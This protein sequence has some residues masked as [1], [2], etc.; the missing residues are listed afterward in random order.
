MLY[1]QGCKGV[2]HMLAIVMA[3]CPDDAFVTVENEVIFQGERR[4]VVFDI[5]SGSATQFSIE[6]ILYTD[7]KVRNPIIVH[8]EGRKL[9]QSAIS[10]KWDGHLSDALDLTLAN[11][12]ARFTMPVRISCV[13]LISAIICSVSGRDMCRSPYGDPL[14]TDGFRGLLGPDGL[15]RVRE[16]LKRIFLCEPSFMI[17]QSDEAYNNL[18]IALANAVPSNSCQCNRCFKDGRFTNH[19]WG[20]GS[21]R[22]T[23]CKVHEVWVA[24]DWFILRGIGA[25]FVSAGENICMPLY[26]SKGLRGRR[27]IL[28]RIHHVLTRTGLHRKSNMFGIRQLHLSLMA[29]ISK[30]TTGTIGISSR[31]CS[32]FP[33]TIQ[34]PLFESPLRLEYILVDGLFHDEHNYYRVLTSDPC[35]NPPRIA[36]QSISGSPIVQSSLGVHTRMT[37]TA[38]PVG[39]QLHVETTVQM[40]TQTVSLDFYKQ[41]VGYMGVNIATKCGH[42]TRKP[43][44]QSSVP[45]IATSVSAPVVY[46]K[47]QYNRDADHNKTRKEVRNLSQI[48]MVLTHNNAE[49]Q[50]LACE[51]G[52][53][54]L[55]QGESCLDC[56]VKEA[57]ELGMELVIQS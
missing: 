18:C 21:V 30:P 4:S 25:S 44:S 38:R 33:T 53:P 45:V 12:G 36:L 57:Y 39:E 19:C 1:F 22:T 14:P 35:P 49:A 48:G 9:C 27:P 31:A 7:G 54:T 46:P 56:A 40:S 8:V 5:Q 41:H 47:L 11:I 16:T 37:L 10:L 50:F 55:F 28:H 24:I 13:E 32:I 20:P 51:L 17:L 52:A 3:L 43:L 6:S 34:N 2:G 23:E 29:V 42:N 26:V 15:N